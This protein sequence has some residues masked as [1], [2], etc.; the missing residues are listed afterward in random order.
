MSDLL[1]VIDMQVGFFHPIIEPI[2][3]VIKKSVEDFKSEVIFT[4]FVN[5]PDSQFYKQLDW[6]RFT[7][8]E[9]Q[10][11]IEE[12][13][14]LAKRCFEHKSYGCLTPEVHTRIKDLGVERIFICGIFTDVCVTK[15]AMD[16]FDIGLETFVIRDAVSTLHGRAVN[17][18]T[19]KGLSYIIGDEHL[20][21]HTQFAKLVG[22][23]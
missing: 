18:A 20:I 7:E 8:K 14:P 13:Q 16:M 4:Q 12:L 22:S 1:F 21:T 17:E 2:I 23:H 15:T 6:T 11:I 10:A 5:D 3:P 9:D 19:L